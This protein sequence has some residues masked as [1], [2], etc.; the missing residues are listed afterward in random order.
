MIHSPT[1]RPKKRNFEW[2]AVK[3]AIASSFSFSFAVLINKC[4]ID[5]M[6]W[7]KPF[8]FGFTYSVFLIIYFIYELET[9]GL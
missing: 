2:G 3:K 6:K 1:A 8:K 9:L 7:F 4:Y 5:E